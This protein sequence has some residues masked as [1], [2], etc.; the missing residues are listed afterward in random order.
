MLS[1]HDLDALL[2]IV[3]DPDVMK[4]LGIEAGTIPSREETKTTLERMI[5]F[6]AQHGFGRWAVINKEDGR[7]IG[8][9]GFRLL[10]GTPELFYVF[11]KANWGRGL[12]TEAAR[13]TL[14]YGFEVL[15]FERIVAVTRHANI[16][17]KNVMIKIGMTYEKQIS[18]S[19]IDAVCYAARRDE[20]QL[21]DS[22]YILSRA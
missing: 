11:A 14:R 1:P 3:S 8:L 17:S 12:A 2:L 18:H 19:G 7:L 9:C 10:D 15:G 20:Y 5:E 22:P 21:D 16:P 4:Y 13:A 6:W